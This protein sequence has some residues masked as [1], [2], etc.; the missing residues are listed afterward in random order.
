ML[1]Q[2][3]KNVNLTN[4]INTIDRLNDVSVNNLA[5]NNIIQ[6]NS[7]TNL[8]ENTTLEDT[9][10]LINGDNVGTGSEVFKQKTGNTL[11]FRTLVAGTGITLTENI[12]DVTIDQTNYIGGGQNNGGNVGI[13]QGTFPDGGGVPILT[14]RSLNVVAPVTIGYDINDD[15]KISLSAEN[16][17]ISNIGTGN[18][19]YKEKIGVD[20]RL[21]TLI[22]GTG[23]SIVNNTNDLTLNLANT[24]VT[25]GS[26]TNSSI[27]VDQQGR[28]TSASDGESLVLVMANKSGAKV[29]GDSTITIVTD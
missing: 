27:T 25:P 10:V 1:N 19:I 6:Y 21:K 13:L 11:E 8:W 14:F 17:T 22:A 29:V 23:T 18:G 20:F 5:D 15:I 2:T 3:N 28:L 9:S 26:Y 16:N 24:A 4:T 7:T 12:N